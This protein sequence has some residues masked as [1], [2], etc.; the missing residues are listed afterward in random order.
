MQVSLKRPHLYG[1]FPTHIDIDID[2]IDTHF[3]ILSTLVIFYNLSHLYK[4]IQSQ[5]LIIIFMSLLNLC[6]QI[7]YQL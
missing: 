5:N 4:E 1:T 2:V 3:Y 6:Y 7:K